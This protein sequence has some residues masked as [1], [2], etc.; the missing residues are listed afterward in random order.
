MSKQSEAKK[1]Q[2]YVPK[3]TPQ[4]CMNCARFAMDKTDNGHGYIEDKNM[5][6]IIGKFA[7]KK[8]GTCNYFEMIF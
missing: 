2:G 4:V 5:R 1:S 6:C 3:A 7:V 8:M